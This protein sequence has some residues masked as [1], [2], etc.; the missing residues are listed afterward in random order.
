M[1]AQK[2]S[3]DE[4]GNVALFAVM[5]VVGLVIGFA[6]GH[7]M[8]NN[9]SDDKKTSSSVAA[10]SMKASDLR[11]DLVTL[12]LEHMTLTASAI[13]Q[14]LD[15]APGAAATDAAL[16]Q[17]GKD[18]GAAVDSVY[19][20][21]GVTFDKVWQLHLDQF[22]A[23]AVA[24][25]KGDAAGKQA[26]L[27]SIDTNYTHPL[28]AFIAKANPNLPEKT[29]YTLLADHVTQTAGVIDDHVNK[30]YTKENADLTAAN[31]HMEGIFSALAAG[32]VAQFPSKF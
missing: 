9:K 7:A 21:A 12:G 19:P 28:A 2:V 25:S 23:Y 26:A 31:K 4:A 3:K 27:T 24:D 22:V 14:T 6:V 18:L 13:D 16:N 29:L 32:I 11:A 15:G 8:D 17:N 20:G 30:D 10:P 1:K 5:L